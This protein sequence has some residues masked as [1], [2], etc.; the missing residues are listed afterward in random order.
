MLPRDPQEPIMDRSHW[1]AV[2]GYG[3]LIT[4]SV[5]GAFAAALVW[6]EMEAALAVTIS[7]LT[8]ALGQLWHVFNMR[9]SESS[10]L[11]NDVTRNVYVWGA[12][13]LCVAL[14]LAAVYVPGLADVL[15]LV[16]PDARGWALVLGASLLPLMLAQALK[17]MRRNRSH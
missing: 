4:L 12:L 8:L 11:F 7:F 13:A 6:L 14:L 3:A 17:Q 2:A 10:V 16:R 9:D 1:L 5:L 15:E